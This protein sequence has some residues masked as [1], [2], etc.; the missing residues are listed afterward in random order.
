MKKIWSAPEAIAE[1]FAAN[2]YVAACGDDNKV[3]KFTCDAPSGTLYA[4]YD[5]DGDMDRLGDYNPCRRY[6][7]SSVN[8]FYCPGFV[9]RNGNRQ[10]DDG[11]A[12]YVWVLFNWWGRVSNAHATANVDMDSWET[13][14]S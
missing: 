12:V 8:D 9:D 6:H 5:N 4:D 14:K 2:E 7:E 11:E 10:E 3:Y 1:Q 13:A